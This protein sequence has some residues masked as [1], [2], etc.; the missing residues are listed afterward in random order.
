MEVKWSLIKV[1]SNRGQVDCYM[2]IG[3][4]YSMIANEN[5]SSPL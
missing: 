4:V 1:R 2:D 5:D 3:N